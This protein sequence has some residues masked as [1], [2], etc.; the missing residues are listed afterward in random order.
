VKKKKKDTNSWGSKFTNMAFGNSEEIES[1]TPLCLP[2][3]NCD[4]S[5]KMKIDPDFSGAVLCESNSPVF[6]EDVAGESATT[7]SPLKFPMTFYGESD[8]KTN[9]SKFSF[10]GDWDLT[11]KGRITFLNEKMAQ[12]DCN[13]S[14][15]VPGA[16][17]ISLVGF[18]QKID[19]EWSSNCRLTFLQCPKLKIDTDKSRMENV[20]VTINGDTVSMILEG[21]QKLLVDTVWQIKEGNII[22]KRVP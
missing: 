5:L 6:L 13:A 11:Y 3:P 7:Q 17:P 2:S 16:K 12:V 9:K 20:I 22:L 1:K 10:G 4:P 15:A 21:K 19:G 8:S 14:C 18:M